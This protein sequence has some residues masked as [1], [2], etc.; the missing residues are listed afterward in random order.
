M[1]YQQAFDLLVERLQVV[2]GDQREARSVARILFED[3][4]QVR[5]LA[6]AGQLAHTELDRYTALS[7]RLVAGE[8]IQYVVGQAFFFGN[9]FIVSPA[10]LIPRP[11]TEELVEW[12]LE[13]GAQRIRETNLLRILDV[14][15]GSGCIAVTL[16]LKL[17]TA[18]VTALDV[19]AD[20]LGVAR[21]NAV[22]YA[23]SLAFTQMNFLDTAAWIHLPKYDLIISNP[24]YVL[25]SDRKIMSSM[26]TEHEP[27]T[28]LFVPDEDP[29]RFYSALSNFAQD[30]LEPGGLLLAECHHAYARHVAALW[31]RE[32]W[33][34]PILRRD[35]SGNERMVGVMR[36]LH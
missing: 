24:P 21:E 29:L 5:N 22:R 31:H 3:A 4:F 23:V 17:P 35:L 19:S 20:A 9:P 28:A 7:N 30:H 25:E 18:R 36:N 8:P 26:V 12:G 10:V 33:R 2:Y 11:E 15:T 32:G 6:H 14:G 13:W 16:K 1:T 27:G 34:E